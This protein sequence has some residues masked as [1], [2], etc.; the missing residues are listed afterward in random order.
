MKD[1]YDPDPDDLR[2]RFPAEPAPTALG[3]A[4]AARSAAK[5]MDRS[6]YQ[7]LSDEERAARLKAQKRASSKRQAKKRLT[8]Q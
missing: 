8:A 3:V 6:E 7:A 1:H 4:R 5:Y 2:R